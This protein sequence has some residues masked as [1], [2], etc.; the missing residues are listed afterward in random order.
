MTFR[1]YGSDPAMTA[2]ASVQC[3]DQLVVL[4]QVQAPA[5]PR[6]TQT[7]PTSRFQDEARS[8]MSIDVPTTVGIGVGIR[9]Y[10]GVIC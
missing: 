5:R 3:R 8:L 10:L 4:P 6:G 1:G 9:D 2:S 7:Q